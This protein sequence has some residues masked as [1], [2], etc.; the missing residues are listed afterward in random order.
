[1]HA[2]LSQQLTSV[3]HKQKEACQKTRKENSFALPNN[4]SQTRPTTHRLSCIK[5][6]TAFAKAA[7][8][9][10]KFLQFDS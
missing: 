5:Y 9:A 1:M 10:E 3:N 7:S 6:A 4:S 8:K 2:K